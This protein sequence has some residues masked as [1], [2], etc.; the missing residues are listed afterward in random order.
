MNNSPYNYNQIRDEV[1]FRF[2]KSYEFKQPPIIPIQDYQNMGYQVIDAYNPPNI[3]T[4]YPV[5]DTHILPSQRLTEFGGSLPSNL[6][7]FSYNA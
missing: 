5:P 3:Q 2:S 7:A 1:D 4:S 6:K